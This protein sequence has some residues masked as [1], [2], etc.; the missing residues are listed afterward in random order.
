[1]K[2]RHLI[3]SRGLLFMEKKFVD[4][5]RFPRI[6]F[7]GPV[8]YHMKE[9][10]RFGGCLARDI[11]EGGIKLNFSDFVPLYSEMALKVQLENDPRVVDMPG[12][13]VWVKQVPFSDRYRIGIEFD[14][15]N[16]LS[17]ETIKSY[18][19]TRRF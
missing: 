9:Q 5:R 13:V 11:S 19:I 15:P 17:K 16:N 12:K 8:H 1:M 4:K 18:V 10:P 6:R 3:E 2:P 7:E 14:H